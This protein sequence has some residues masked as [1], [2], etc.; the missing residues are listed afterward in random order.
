M[1]E[2]EESGKASA[3]T[4]VKVIISYNKDKFK[5]KFPSKTKVAHIEEFIKRK[6]QIK[7]TES[8]YLFDKHRKYLLHSNSSIQD[9]A[10]RQALSRKGELGEADVE[11]VMRLSETYGGHHI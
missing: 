8:A 5:L 1:N 11:I 6:V 3:T 2:T 7:P 9:V 4:F 10:E